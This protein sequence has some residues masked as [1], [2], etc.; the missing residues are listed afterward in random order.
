MDL[1]SLR[2]FLSLCETLSLTRTAAQLHMSLSAV[3]RVL[4]KL[5]DDLGCRLLERDNRNVRLTAAAADAQRSARL[6]V[7]EWLSL[8]QRLRGDLAA[9]SGELSI[10]C[11][12]T[13]SH[14][15]LA[16]VLERFRA[17]HPAVDIQLRT[18]DQ[19]DAIARVL[20]GTDDLGIAAQP[21]ALPARL[22]YRAL[23]ET[24]LVFIAPLRPGPLDEWL[25][26]GGS[27]RKVPWEQLPFIVPARGATKERLDAWLK[28]QR[29]KPRVYAQVAGHEAIVAMVALGLGVGLVPE[30]VLESAPAAA[31]VRLLSPRLPPMTIGLCAL[32]QRLDVPAVKRFW[33]CAG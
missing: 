8:Q 2:V 29:L 20:A 32:R 21:R 28:S 15:V 19:A 23:R 3:S 13:A 18:G 31:D 22:A 11:S 4:Q 33:E 27:R 1:K 12:V 9:I 7:E 5:E 16:P 6:M 14:S 30:L 10:Y 17:A 26:R 25:P 24:P